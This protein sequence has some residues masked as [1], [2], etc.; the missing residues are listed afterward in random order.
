MLTANRW[1]GWHLAV[2]AVLLGA[3]MACTR[4]S[5]WWLDYP[6]V[7]KA[8]PFPATEILSVP[9]ARFRAYAESLPY[10]SVHGAGDDQ[11]LLLRVEVRGK[12]TTRFYGPR[13]RIEPVRGEFR[14]DSA[15]FAQGRVIARIWSSGPYPKLNLQAGWTYWWVDGVGG[16]W[17]SVMISGSL[18]TRD[19][20]RLEFHNYRDPSD[21]EYQKSRSPW[22]QDIARFVWTESDEQLWRN[23]TDSGCC[24]R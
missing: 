1:R 20:S 4:L 5:R 21:S 15:G 8:P 24:R 6:E 2:V 10:D 3:V 16:K 19:T 13:A 12:D 9:I 7:S 14:A 18:D 17:R 11:R 23:C 22:R